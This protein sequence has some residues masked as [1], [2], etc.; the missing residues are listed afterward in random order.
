MIFNRKRKAN[1]Q[2]VSVHKLMFVCS[3]DETQWNPGCQA[4]D[5]TPSSRIP[6]SCIRATKQ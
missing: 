3:L 5:S 1:S 6:R 4:F 2:P